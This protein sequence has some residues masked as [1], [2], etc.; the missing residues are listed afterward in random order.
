MAAIIA[1]G[2][3]VGVF[4]VGLG[5]FNIVNQ[6]KQVIGKVQET[7]EIIQS[8]DITE[9]EKEYSVQRNSIRLLLNFGSILMRGCAA[10]VL[11]FTVLAIFH[12]ANIAS[13]D[14]SL[15]I[16]EQWQTLV[17]ITIVVSVAA[18]LLR[19]RKKSL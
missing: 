12:Y 18:I 13:I 16:L 6:A 9:K 11:G 19:S 10:L 4:F 17:I 3:S 7:I 15:N 14:S 1:V 2:L 8:S 5:L